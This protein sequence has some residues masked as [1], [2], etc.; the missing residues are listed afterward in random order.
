MRATSS[1]SS[2]LHEEEEALVLLLFFFFLPL[3]YDVNCVFS[4]FSENKKN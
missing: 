4:V 1:S 2:E 3:L